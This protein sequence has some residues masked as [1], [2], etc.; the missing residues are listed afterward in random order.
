[1]NYVWTQVAINSLTSQNKL[2]LFQNPK[3]DSIM[4]DIQLESW[5]VLLNND[6]LSYETLLKYD[7]CKVAQIPIHKPSVKKVK[8]NIKVVKK[9]K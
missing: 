9:K 2:E 3:I 5:K 4:N 8:K 6:S 1:M 7:L